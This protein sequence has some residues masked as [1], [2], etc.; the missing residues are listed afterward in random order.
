MNFILAERY[1]LKYLII[2]NGYAECWTLE[3]HPYYRSFSEW[4]PLFKDLNGMTVKTISHKEGLTILERFAD[5]SAFGHRI[6]ALIGRYK[7]LPF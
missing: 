1:G 4:R 6:A 7:A 2:E 3:I 5:D